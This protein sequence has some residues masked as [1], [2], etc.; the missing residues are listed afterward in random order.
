MLS[1]ESFSTLTSLISESMNRTPTSDAVKAAIAAI[2]VFGYHPKTTSDALATSEAMKLILSS[3]LR[4]MPPAIQAKIE[5]MMSSE[6]VE[7]RAKSIMASD[8]FPMSHESHIK[9]K[10]FPSIAKTVDSIQ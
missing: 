2:D 4:G 1:N 3:G 8:S 9:N 5:S 10:H 7:K 6:T